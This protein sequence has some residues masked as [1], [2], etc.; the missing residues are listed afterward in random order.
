MENEKILLLPNDIKIESYKQKFINDI[1]SYFSHFNEKLIYMYVEKGSNN[2]IIYK[3][4]HRTSE[5]DIKHFELK[6]Y[7][8]VF[9]NITYE[10]KYEKLIVD[11]I[12]QN[13]DGKIIT[14]NTMSDNIYNITLDSIVNYYL[15]T[16][17][18]LNVSIK[19]VQSYDF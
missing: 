6:D 10:V 14:M 12:I 4:K 7:Y 17:K 8:N 2:Y 5:W 19:Y 11:I 13:L 3:C 1:I 18:Q 15:G 16:L 9:I